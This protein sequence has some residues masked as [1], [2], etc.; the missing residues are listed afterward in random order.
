MASIGDFIPEFDTRERFERRVKAPPEVV[1]RTAYDFDMQS[2]W[3]IRAIVNA[4]KV[5]LGGTWEKRRPRGIVD[6]TRGLGWG[7]LAEEPGRLLI[8]GAV[9][10]PWFGD[11]VFTPIPPE[12]FAAYNEPDQV[13][14]AWTLEAEEAEP[15]LTLFIHEVRAVATDDDARRKFLKYWRWA[16]FGIIAIRLLLLPAIKKRAESRS[17]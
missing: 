2:I 11:V 8:C 1:M 6:E 13:K 12:D 17:T 10:Q 5:V 7:T 9:C 4:R 16:R 14:I 3:L 15:G